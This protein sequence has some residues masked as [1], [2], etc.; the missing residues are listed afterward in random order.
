M[1]FQ[2]PFKIRA[3]API[4]AASLL[5]MLLAAPPAAAQTP[6]VS[7]GAAAYTANEGTTH[8]IPINLSAAA[9]AAVTV[10]YAFAGTA[11][12][13]NPNFDFEAP[14][15]ELEIA[16]GASTANVVVQIYNDGFRDADETLTF[17]LQP[18]SGY[19]AG[20]I[21]TAVLTITDTTQDIRIQFNPTISRLTED[22]DMHNDDWR[23]G[24]ETTSDHPDFAIS[25]TATLAEGQTLLT[26]DRGGDVERNGVII[27]PFDT[28]GTTI[29]PGTVN[30]RIPAGLNFVTWPDNMAA[31]DDELVEHDESC[32]LGLEPYTPPAGLPYA[33]VTAKPSEANGAWTLHITDNDRDDAT[34]AFGENA[35]ATF[36]YTA[37][38][39]E[40]DG[41]LNVP[42]TI[43]AP[44]GEAT[45]FYVDDI[46][47]AGGASKGAGGDYTIASNQL[48][49]PAQANQAARTQN[50]VITLNDDSLFEGDEKITLRLRAADDPVDDLGDYYAR[51]NAAVA[52]I[53]ITSAD[54]PLPPEFTVLP[55][56]QTLT[57]SWSPD[58]A[59]PVDTYL[60]RWR[61]AD[62]G[63]SPGSWENDNGEDGVDT[64]SQTTYEITGLTNGS[65]YEVQ[66]A[67]FTASQ[68]SDWSD[69]HKAEANFTL[70]VDGRAGMTVHDGM[71]MVRYLFGVT[72][73]ELTDDLSAAD[74]AGITANLD[75]AKTAGAL[76][77][78][79]ETGAGWKDGVLY[80]RYLAG[81]RGEDLVAGLGIAED[82]A[83]VA[84]NIAG[85]L[86]GP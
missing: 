74:A 18:P 28:I 2:T 62:D 84:A 7:F 27:S 55:S 68:R 79:G 39:A 3:A 9:T 35:A 61:L 43:S 49:F 17:T 36:S 31:V 52:H 20:D 56:L 15:G 22:D 41:T 19:A 86:P 77:V 6:T 24:L 14:S 73:A 81:L 16:S 69:A 80:A 5:V 40:A 8:N 4:T 60:A 65:T 63:G 59:A 32:V 72:G 44:P 51:N 50:L 85:N 33:V 42:V 46:T 25:V 82:A 12:S 21:T 37:T 76:D 13:A 26:G 70:D 45:T 11:K 30:F 29:C 78:D 57:L 23:L 10:T 83:T 48:A 66:M 71:L 67:S 54:P 1:T 64:E 34:I 75:A 47:A 53:T 58:P 38:A